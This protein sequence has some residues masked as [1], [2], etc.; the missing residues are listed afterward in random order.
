MLKIAK[1]EVIKANIPRRTPFEIA[2]GTL[3]IATRVFVRVTLE[4]GTVG[5]GECAVHVGTGERGSVAI[6]SEETQ[7][8]CH[9]IL[10]EQI[11]PAVLGLDALD[12]AN[13]HRV[14]SSVTL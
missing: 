11:G 7:S 14:I 8:T 13:V 1:V 9:T 3:V 2:R 10:V 5:Y 12:M 6:Y 4:D